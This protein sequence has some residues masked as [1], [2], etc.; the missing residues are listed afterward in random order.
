MLKLCNTSRTRSVLVKVT[1]AILVTVMPCAL[2]STICARR[3]VTTD[4]ELRRTIR[5][6]R[7]P[8]SLLMGRTP[9]RSAIAP[10]PCEETVFS[11]HA[12]RANVAGR[13]TK[14]VRGIGLRARVGVR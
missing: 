11:H 3:H 14:E 2:N 4:P 8:S 12:N 5:S 10:P 13:G 6:S 7:L 1:S 9:T